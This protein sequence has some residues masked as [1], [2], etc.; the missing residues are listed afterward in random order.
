MVGTKGNSDMSAAAHVLPL[1]GLLA[2]SIRDRGSQASMNALIIAELSKDTFNSNFKAD[3][4]L[5]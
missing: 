1:N 2:S 5:N 3:L 4:A